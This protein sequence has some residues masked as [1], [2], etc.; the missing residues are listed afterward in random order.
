[1]DT[2]L[3][4]SE[5]VTEGHPDKLCDKISD[6]ILDAC[7]EQ[8]PDS[9]V[10]FETCIKSNIVT[11]VGEITTKSN[12]YYD[13]IVRD[14]CRAIGYS[15]PDLGLDANTCEVLVNIQEQNPE[16]AQIVH[17]NFTK[18]PEEIG[19]GDQ[20]HMFGYATDETSQLMP[21]SHVLA[22][23][24]AAKLDD[25]R[26]NGTCPFLRPVGKT[27]VIVE[28]KKEG[29]A[30]IPIRVHTMI[31]STQHDGTL[32]NEEIE[33]E[34]REQVI[35]P[36]VPSK[37]LDEKT[38]FSI[39]QLD[40]GP[41][42]HAGLSGRNI[43]VDT[44]GGWGAHGGGA[45][46]GKDATKVHR[47]G[48]YIARQVAKSVV[49]L[50]LARRCIVQV[51]YAIGIPEPVSVFVDTY[52]TGKMVDRDILKLVMENFDFRPG[53]IAKD[54]DL[55]RGGNFRYQKTAAYGHFGRDDPDFTWEVV[56][57]LK[58]K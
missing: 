36:V 39:K 14:T 15:S 10:D 57:M 52:G 16:I 6:A 34:L 13:N 4:T 24:A 3:F 12:V 49:E 46:S 19:A 33:R 54:L 50:G 48:A 32:T 1:M 40:M 35:K 56:R 2:F 51:S 5:S 29:G 44:Y 53:M 42:E 7:L 21:L 11:V 22:S 47:S 28:H 30:I 31:I 17:G 8:D 9:K 26:K 23:E 43:I 18:K 41:H 20:G 27:E 25:V 58:P 37:Y 45:F 55:K 38:V